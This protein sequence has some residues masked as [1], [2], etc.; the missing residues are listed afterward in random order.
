MEKKTPLSDESLMW[1]YVNGDYEAFESLYQRHSKKV[2]GYIF[3]K[4][5]NLEESS[6][7]FQTVFR[8]LHASLDKYKEGLLFLPWLFTIAKHAIIDN[9]RKEKRILTYQFSTETIENYADSSSLSDDQT[10]SNIDGYD[11]L[12][13]NEKEVLEL[14]YNEEYNFKEIAE[15]LGYSADNARK[16][17]SRAINKL[18]QF[19]KKRMTNE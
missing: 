19:R 18:K 14:K 9:K 5:Q 7:I 6:E 2:F 1:K 8:K 11:K 12:K 3:L 13:T 4:V 15:I 10:L 17:S 16:I